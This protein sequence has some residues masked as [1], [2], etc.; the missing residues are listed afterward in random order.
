MEGFQ[1]ITYRKAEGVAY[2]SL[3]RPDV[4]N[5]YN[6]Q[7]RDEMYQALGAVKVD[8]EVGVA[9]LKG[10]GPSFCAGADLTEFG[11]AP[12]Q[13][14]ARAVRWERDVW[15]KFLNVSKPIIAAIHGYCLGSGLEM[16]LLCDFRIAAEGTEFGMPEVSL[17]MIPAAGG[18][19][20]LPRT[21]GI[22]RALETLL[23][24]RR[25][26][27][28]EAL[29]WGLVTKVVTEQSLASETDATARQLLSIDQ[30]VLMAV[31]KAVLRGSDL[32]LDQALELETRLA[33]RTMAVRRG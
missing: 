22:P 28:Q 7:M 14:T 26:G 11:T 3:N 25:F 30:Q 18:T 23:T 2:I 15:G 31:K 32:P 8:S 20:T 33:L 24:R 9:V 6:M 4:H 10:E 13:T 12:S 1:T 5:A 27:S 16:A 19:Q 17:G 21:L 29:E